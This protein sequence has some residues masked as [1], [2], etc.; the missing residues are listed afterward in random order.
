MT[1]FSIP[2]L[3]TE[4][5]ILRAPKLEDFEP[6]SAFYGQ[7]RSKFV[8]D[9]EM[10]PNK[11][12]RSLAHVAGLWVL[13]GYGLFILTLKDDDAPL[14]V[15]GAF[16]PI[17]HP[18]PELGWSL[19]DAKHEGHGYITEAAIACRAYVYNVHKW[20]TAVSYIEPENAASIKV[21]ERL[22]CVLDEDAKSPGNY[23][24]L[25]Y[26]HPAPEALS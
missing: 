8:R 2:T 24:C 25:V 12:W 13:R 5:L 19:W 14:G 4:R 9:G 6:L 26:R 22:G 10:T 3:E 21:A 23:P 17:D 1:S 7:E 15:A 18:E 20:T 11:C 16:H